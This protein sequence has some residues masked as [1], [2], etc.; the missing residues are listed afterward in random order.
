M[1]S[2]NS[3]IEDL[4]NRRTSTNTNNSGRYYF[5]IGNISNKNLANITVKT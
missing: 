1:H 4:I 5:K 2:A 3:E